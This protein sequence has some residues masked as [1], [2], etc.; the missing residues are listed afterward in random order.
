M[1]V[2]NDKY[3]QNIREINGIVFGCK[4]IKSE[5]DSMAEHLASIYPEKLLNI[6]EVM[7]PELIE[8]YG[9]DIKDITVDE[10]IERLGKPLINLDLNII[11]FPN[12]TFDLVH[13]ISVDF[14]D[15]FENISG[16]SVDG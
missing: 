7:I 16:F 4:S 8:F 12:Q 10:T 6:V 15:D 11:N 3:R 1:F 13:I 9:D 5:Y 2:Y 14:C